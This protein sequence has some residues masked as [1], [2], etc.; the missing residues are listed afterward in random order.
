MEEIFST[1]NNYLEILLTLRL[2]SRILLGVP[3][4]ISH[5]EGIIRMTSGERL[6]ASLEDYLEAIFHIVQKKQAAKAKDIALHLNVSSSSVTGALQ[7]LAKRGLINYAPYDL[8]TLTP[9]GIHL[10]KDVIHRH[11]TL[12]YFLA[13]VLSIDEE[14]AQ[15]A[16]CRMEHVISQLILERLIQFVKFVEKCPVGGAVWDDE[17]G[18]ICKHME[19][20]G[21]CERCEEEIRKFFPTAG[22]KVSEE[23]E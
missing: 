15:D 4:I 14:E 10:A 5:D 23:I 20:Y 8:I 9:D 12:H 6:S 2:G 19:I 13:N 11:E 16:A 1:G 21:S 22:D 7:S 17:R 18:F 3:N